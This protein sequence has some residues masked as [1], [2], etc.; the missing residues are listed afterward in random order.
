M[1][2]RIARI[3][4]LDICGIDVMAPDVNTP[5]TENGGAIL[6]V[7][8]AP[9]FRMHLSPTEG[10]ARNVAAPVI[11]M[12]FPKGNF[13]RIPIVAVTG[14]NGKTTTTRLIAHLANK[15]GCHAGFTTNGI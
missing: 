9:G 14:T 6:E 4:G 5:I 15:S 8:A 13:V 10:I 2:E 3:V 12:L 11:D 1:A 7:N